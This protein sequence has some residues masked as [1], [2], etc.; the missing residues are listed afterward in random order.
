MSYENT[1]CPCGDTKP[2]STMLCD[3]CVSDLSSRPEYRTFRDELA[4][5]GVRRH[6]AIILLSLSRKR[7]K[8]MEL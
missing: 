8:Q 3:G 6:A 2:Q 4:P 1:H 5:L 7:K